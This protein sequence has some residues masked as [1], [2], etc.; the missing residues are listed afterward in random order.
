[1]WLHTIDDTDAVVESVARGAGPLRARV[2]KTLVPVMRPLVKR[3][4]GI[5]AATERDALEG[6]SAAMDR[7]ESEVGPSGYLVGES[8][9]VADLTAAALFTPLICPPGRQ[10][11]PPQVAPEIRALRDELEA[12][13]GGAWVEETYRRHRGVS[14]ELVA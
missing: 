11:P 6:I 14:A 5:S 13:D 7:V 9:S 1:M 8:F 10:Y 12:R 2:V 3:D 4:Y